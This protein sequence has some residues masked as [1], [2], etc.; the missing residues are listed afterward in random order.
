METLTESRCYE[1]APLEQRPRQVS[2][3]TDSLNVS[4]DA[5]SLLGE[6]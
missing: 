3:A 5:S 1:V 4:I 6:S 2:L